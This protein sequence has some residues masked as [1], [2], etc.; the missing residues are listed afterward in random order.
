MC[1]YSSA[2]V[3]AAIVTFMRHALQVVME[4]DGDLVDAILLYHSESTALTCLI[5]STNSTSL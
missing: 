5:Q 2:Y 4:N 3:A 1:Q